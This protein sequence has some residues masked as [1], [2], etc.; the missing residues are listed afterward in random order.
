MNNYVKDKVIVITGAGSGFG[1]LVA[2][3]TAAMGARVVGGD[4]NLETV[5]ETADSIIADGGEALAVRC[6]V[7]ALA[8]VKA[9]VASA[10][11]RFGR[12]D[13]MI[14]NAGVMPL[15][16]FADHEE[17]MPQWERCID[18]NFKGVLNGCVA[19]HDQMISQGRGHI[20]N[21]SSIY[22]N[23]PVMGGAVYGA[24]KSAVNFLSESLRIETRGKIKVTVIKPSAVPTT[25]LSGTVVNMEA[26]VGLLGH[27]AEGFMQTM[28]QIETNTRPEVA[29]D[30]ESIEF[31]MLHPEPIADGIVH[32]INQPWGVVVADLTVR[33]SADFCV[34]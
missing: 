11:E 6:D 1:R 4:I 24:T 19:A 23:Y 16:F 31:N 9:L 12:V 29:A 3:K 13:V 22:S 34:I 30:P 20:I 14:N 8:S 32:A 5:T 21:L 25:G 10:V 17:A 18:I 15:A 2:Q 7:T 26:A 28:E 33:P 27:N